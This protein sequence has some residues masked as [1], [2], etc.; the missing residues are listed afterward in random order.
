MV[1]YKG[2]AATV[3][4]IRVWDTEKTSADFGITETPLPQLLSGEVENLFHYLVR[5][6][7]FIR[8][9]NQGICGAV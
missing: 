7:R 9:N 4:G 5:E 2:Y 8:R 1:T 6:T 3:D